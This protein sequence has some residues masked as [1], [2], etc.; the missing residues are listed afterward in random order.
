MR[1][2]DGLSD[3]SSRCE[4]CGGS[5]ALPVGCLS[6][7]RDCGFPCM[8][9]K[10]GEAFHAIEESDDYFEA[11]RVAEDCDREA[12]VHTDGSVRPAHDK[13]EDCD[14]DPATDL[15]RGCQVLH[16]DPCPACGGRG[17]HRPGCPES[18]A[19]ADDQRALVEV[20]RTSL[21]RRPQ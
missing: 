12:I 19:T 7:C 21:D 2:L 3:G 15:C 9:E 8:I 1:R 10:D 17:Y 11:R 14:V 13:D 18:D 4:S 6:C 20:L 16:G 5:R